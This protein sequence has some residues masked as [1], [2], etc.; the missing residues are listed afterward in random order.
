[1]YKF[2]GGGTKYSDHDK[3]WAEV[4]QASKES[5]LQ[6]PSKYQRP[7]HSLGLEISTHR[8]PK[9]AMMSASIILSGALKEEVRCVF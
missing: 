2:G 6:H 8:E 4:L 3:H 7:K 9:E 1:M 5:D